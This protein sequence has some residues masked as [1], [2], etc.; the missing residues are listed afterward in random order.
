MIRTI[1]A[2]IIRLFRDQVANFDLRNTL[3]LARPRQLH[4]EMRR[5]MTVSVRGNEP[6]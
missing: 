1:R 6:A 5:A 4:S 3:R 2:L